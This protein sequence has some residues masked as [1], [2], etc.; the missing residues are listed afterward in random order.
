M[1]KKLSLLLVLALMI[2]LVPMSAFAGSDNGVSG[3]VKVKDDAKLKAAAP[4]LKIENDGGDWGSTEKIEL[5]L[6]GADW[7]DD[8]DEGINTFNSDLAT[9]IESATETVTV[10]GVVYGVDATVERKSDSRIILTLKA[11]E[12]GTVVTNPIHEDIVVRIPMWVEMD[13]EVGKVS[14]ESKSGLITETTEIF[15]EG[16]SGD[17]TVEI[18]DTVTFSTTKLIEN[19]VIEENAI[20]TFK[21]S[22]IGE[23]YIKLTLDKDFKW[24]LDNNA[25]IGGDLI[26]EVAINSV[27]ANY[28][29]DDNELKIYVHGTKNGASKGYALLSDNGVIGN[30]EITG[31]QVRPTRDAKEGKVYVT[32]SSD[33]N[34]IKRTKLELGEYA[35][36]KVEVKADGDAEEIFSGRFEGALNNN[37][38]FTATTKELVSGNT[39]LESLTTDEEHELQKLIIEEKVDGSWTHDKTVVVEFPSWVKILGV[40]RSEDEGDKIVKEEIDENVYEFE[41]NNPNGKIK[42]G[43]EF[44]VSVEAGKSGDITAKVSGK[45]LDDEYE[46]V[47]GKAIAPVKVEAEVAKIKAGVRDQE[48][49]KITITEAKAGAIQ[50]GNIVLELDKD[51][52]WDDEPTV[53]VVKGDLE[54]EEDDIDVKDNILTIEVTDESTE[55]SVIEITNGEVKVDRSIAEGR[56][57]VEVKGD[58]LI[59]N[60]YDKEVELKYNDGTTS[61]KL[62]KSDL[63]DYYGLFNED[64]Y[65]KVEVANVITPA[66]ADTKAA[67]P[68]KFVIGNAEYQVGDE[69]KTADVA[70]YIKDG[71]TMLSLRYVAE[72]MGVSNE[73]I[74]WD[75]ATR[76]VTIFKGDRI[77][78]VQIGSNKLMVGG[79]TITMDTVAEIKDGRTMLPVSFVA[80]A[81]GAQ[82]EWDGATRTVTIK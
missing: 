60:G 80:K 61:E 18:E 9:A 32:V 54:I 14:I 26:N 47:L 8:G 7:L 22:D 40:E 48:I 20:G 45:A 56:I 17:T 68:A 44:Y 35:E 63:L 66:D 67:E 2:S 43:L 36:Y 79:A 65:A 71:R 21:L 76:T 42:V 6:E 19:I 73:N 4:E 31:L 82:V 75:G 57:D 39:Q 72:A 37:N 11:T 41:V 38:E 81:L 62:S 55:P 49:G 52:E 34:E 77:A 1:K 3:K 51:M 53:K 24:I 27:A 70:P 25:K 50:E 74:M 13:G 29:L 12:N 30:I 15:A 64:Y 5:K 10:S 59:Q 28:E 78:Q 69:V 33:M 58:A 23:K 16:K 46:V